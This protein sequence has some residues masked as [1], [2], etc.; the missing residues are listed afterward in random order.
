M[1]RRSTSLGCCV[2]AVLLV[3]CQECVGSDA[4]AGVHDDVIQRAVGG[5]E[6]RVGRV[7]ARS[8]CE[9]EGGRDQIRAAA[10][11]TQTPQ[12]YVHLH[13][14]CTSLNP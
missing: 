12:E 14:S 6:E 4:A 7:E 13:E 2:C 9:D 8:G 10:A 5:G 3:V 1:A 11:Q